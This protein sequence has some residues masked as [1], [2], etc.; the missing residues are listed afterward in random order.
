MNNTTIMDLRKGEIL[1]LEE[2]I[3]IAQGV[4]QWNMCYRWDNVGG[5]KLS[6]DM[7]E[8]NIHVEV[9]RKAFST[10]KYSIILSRNKKK[11]VEYND[12]W[13]F[14]K[15][16]KIY[17]IAMKNYDERSKM[18]YSEHQKALVAE[19]ETIRQIIHKYY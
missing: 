15:I 6:G 8:N 19:S 13:P 4:N 10:G 7:V 17:E 11:I 3:G 1:S 2:V 12:R 9:G 16:A 18:E 14:S 5:Y